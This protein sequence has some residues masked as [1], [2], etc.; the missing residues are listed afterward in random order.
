MTKVPDRERWFSWVMIAWMLAAA[1][2]IAGIFLIT[3]LGYIE[4]PTGNRFITRREPN[5]MIWA[6]AI[7]QALGA[8]MLAVIFH[9]L[10]SIYQNS[11][12]QL[13]AT[14][15]QSPAK[16]ASPR[17]ARAGDKGVRLTE[18]AQNSPLRGVLSVGCLVARVNGAPVESVGDIA[19]SIEKGGNKFE[20]DT[21]A[22]VSH[23][24]WVHLKLSE[25]LY[26]K[27]EVT[28]IPT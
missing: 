26:I 13:A 16:P 11:C 19:E 15:A 10:H 25:P 6:L 4:L 5:V 18:V 8:I 21:P 14:V 12:D 3:E 23:E 17:P 22:G 24:K 2:V 28:E 9:M 7:G 20:F 27:G 1:S